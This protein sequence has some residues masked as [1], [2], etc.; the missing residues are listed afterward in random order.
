MLWNVKNGCVRVG[1]SDMSY[2]SFGYG[3]KAFVLLPGLSDGLTTV[4]GK[5]L[6]L[7]KPYKIFL[8]NI[9][10]TYSAEKTICRRDMPF[11]IWRMTKQRP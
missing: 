2:V 9:L 10:F 7:S 4:R 1:D 6:L 3:E 5:A 8:R 11:E